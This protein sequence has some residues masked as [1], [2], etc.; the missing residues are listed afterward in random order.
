MGFIRIRARRI[1]IIFKMDAFFHGQISGVH[2]F[3][4]AIS[5]NTKGANIDI[6]IH[7][8]PFPFATGLSDLY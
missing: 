8:C 6:I 5:Y 1:F 3:S 2:S 7:V 4:S